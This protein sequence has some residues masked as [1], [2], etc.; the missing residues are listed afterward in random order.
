MGKWLFLIFCIAVSLPSRAQFSVNDSNV[1]DLGLDQTVLISIRL[2]ATENLTN[3]EPDMLEPSCLDFFGDGVVNITY[4]GDGSSANG[5]FTLRPLSSWNNGQTKWLG[6]YVHLLNSQTLCENWSSRCGGLMDFRVQVA[7]N[8]ASRG[9]G[10][11]NTSLSADGPEPNTLVVDHRLMESPLSMCQQLIGGGITRGNLLN[12]GTPADYQSKRVYLGIN[13]F[14][15]I[16]AHGFTFLDGF[17][18]FTIAGSGTNGTLNVRQEYVAGNIPLIDQNTRI[19]DENG[20]PFVMGPPGGLGD[21]NEVCPPPTHSWNFLDVT[22]AVRG[23]LPN[24]NTNPIFD[25]TPG[26]TVGRFRQV[27]LFV[28]TEKNCEPLATVFGTP[29]NNAFHFTSMELDDSFGSENR[30]R[31]GVD[32][33][34]AW[35]ASPN[36][37]KSDYQVRWYYR[38]GNTYSSASVVS[39]SND[40]R[41]LNPVLSIPVSFGD[42]YQIEARITHT[43]SGSVVS[44]RSIYHPLRYQVTGSDSIEGDDQ[45]NYLDPGEQFVIPFRLTNT[46]S[47][48]LN[49]VEITMGVET[50]GNV[51]MAFRNGS[52]PARM[53]ETANFGAVSIGSG[54]VLNLDLEYELI[55]TDLVCAPLRVFIEV[56][57]TVDGVD[58]SYRRTFDIDTANCSFQTAV[59]SLNTQNGASS[60]S[61]T[62]TATNYTGSPVPCGDPNCSNATPIPFP[63]V[64]D[65]WFFN[66][67]TG[68]WTG[69]SLIKNR[70]HVLES[71]SLVTGLN[72]A[73]FLQHFNDLEERFAGGVLEFSLDGGQTWQD[74]IRA[75]EVA[76]SPL[77]LYNKFFLFPPINANFQD[78]IIGD[79]AVFMGMSCIGQPCSANH[80][81]FDENLNRQVIED[82]GE[83][84]PLP[85]TIFQGSS[86]VKFRFV[87]QIAVLPATGNWIV[88]QFEYHRDS[89]VADDFFQVGP[90]EANTCNPAVS[91]NPAGNG[92][93]TFEWYS[94]FERLQD[95]LPDE[96]TSVGTWNGFPVPD[97]DSVYYVRIIDNNGVERVHSIDIEVIGGGAPPL[98]FEINNWGVIYNAAADLNSDGFVDVRDLIRSIILDACN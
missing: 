66:S 25:L 40:F 6:F 55:Y 22:D 35:L 14:T 18:T 11:F 89:L 31:V 49:N 74:L 48:A 93:F 59:S 29:I 91:V 92:P 54:Q 30:V 23:R 70:Y 24:I 53:G 57:S 36:L 52:G 2:T 17:G 71:P 75:M 44:T 63:V 58:T 62:W 1:P 33:P 12:Y 77:R 41:S 87:Y 86:T 16:A 76:N 37:L 73:I 61:T 67:S 95:D 85:P 20:V 19:E 98:S 51:L 21:I 39:A 96:V 43:A 60:F 27:A 94:S 50:S 90:L 68:V 78:N 15:N 46:S 34:A 56:S 32:V 9:E 83:A 10:I 5:P 38:N 4:A 42:E 88:D 79:R 45:D 28:I 82:D 84:F 72:P 7:Y 64:N 97:T 13:W 81:L 26:R 47:A 8:S 3:V 69:S 80:D 65:G